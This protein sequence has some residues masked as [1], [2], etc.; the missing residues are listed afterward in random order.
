MP[1]RKVNSPAIPLE[2]EPSSLQFSAQFGERS[3][4]K[5]QLLL[6]SLLITINNYI[7]MTRVIKIKI[8]VV[9]VIKIILCM[10]GSIS[11]NNL[12]VSCF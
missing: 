4:A 9:A 12:D 2:I 5:F 6:H 1:T 7:D 10:S 3:L 8:F 11:C